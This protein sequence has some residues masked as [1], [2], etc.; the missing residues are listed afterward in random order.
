MRTALPTFVYACHTSK[1][2]VTQNISSGLGLEHIAMVANLS[3]VT[4]KL[5]QND[6]QVHFRATKHV[7]VKQ[8]EEGQPVEGP[9]DSGPSSHAVRVLCLDDSSIARKSL[10]YAFQQHAPNAIV[11]TFGESADE[12]QLFKDSTRS[13]CDMIIVDQVILLTYGWVQECVAAGARRMLLLCDRTE[14]WHGVR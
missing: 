7:E 1:W 8:H 14:R 9:Q 5:W 10:R 12:V 6:N 3:G 11:H 4:A 2:C 13:E